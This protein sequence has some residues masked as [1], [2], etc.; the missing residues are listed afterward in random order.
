MEN[1]YFLDLNNINVNDNTEKKGRF[2][3]L[4]WAWAWAELKKRY[5]DATYNVHKF[6][7]DNKPYLFDE[8][9]GYMVFTD[10]T[11]NGLTHEMWL[12]VMDF[13]NKAIQQG[14]ATMM[15][16]NK[17]IMRCLVKNIGMHGIGLY[18][19]AG[20]DLPEEEDGK[21]PTP[22]PKRTN[23]PKATDKQIGLIESLYSDV[24]LDTMLTRLGKGLPQ[25][26]VEEASKMISARK[27]DK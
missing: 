15:E 5:P 27:G 16:I 12:P 10:V 8:D 6:G 26:T 13:N 21:Q 19:Y 18:I 23:S 2:T 25:L 3:Y 9:L 24:E 4:S 7:E 17:A 14:K 1:N 11:V 22:K 20:E